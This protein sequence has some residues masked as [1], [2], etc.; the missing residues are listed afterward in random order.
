MTGFLLSDKVKISSLQ[1]YDF[2]ETLSI[3]EDLA[4]QTLSFVRDAIMYDEQ[5]KIIEPLSINKDLAKQTLRF[6]KDAIMCDE[7]KERIEKW[8]KES[9]HPDTKLQPPSSQKEDQNQDSPQKQIVTASF[10]TK[11]SPRTNFHASR[12]LAERQPQGQRLSSSPQQSKNNC[13]IVS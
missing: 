9:I 13:C 5:E 3:K 11:G 4:K 1:E 6:T 2:I 12:V 10:V 8:I 7:K